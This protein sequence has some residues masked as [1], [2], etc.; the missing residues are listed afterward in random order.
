MMVC[1][2]GTMIKTTVL[3]MII[4]IFPGCT[5]RSSQSLYVKEGVDV[6][7]IKDAQIVPEQV[8]FHIQTLFDSSCALSSCHKGDAPAGELTLIED[9]AYGMLINVPAVGDK[10]KVRI[11]PYKPEESYL[12][13]KIT[14]EAESQVPHTDLLSHVEISAMQ[15]WIED[16]AYPRFHAPSA[17]VSADSM[18]AEGDME[19]DVLIPCA[20]EKPTWENTIQL[21]TDKYCRP[22]HDGADPRKLAFVPYFV[23]DYP[24]A[25]EKAE[26][27]Y[28]RA[29][30]GT[31]PSLEYPSLYSGSLLT[32]EE[33]SCIR[34]WID[35]GV[36]E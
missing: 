26:R 23:D 7:F 32:D 13:L 12:F 21:M 18:D 14:G 30:T 15:K 24:V 16:G 35:Q 20:I 4:L 8:P 10:T 5:K 2:N 33:I 6:L 27:I 17:D 34:E 3:L 9:K 25:K 19:P 36:R 31:M 1:P 28:I 11:R 29:K 22:C